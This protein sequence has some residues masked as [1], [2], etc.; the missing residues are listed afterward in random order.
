MAV[1]YLHNKSLTL[2]VVIDLHSDLFSL[3]FLQ[4]GLPASIFLNTSESLEVER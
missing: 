1:A 3:Y 2:L 4:V